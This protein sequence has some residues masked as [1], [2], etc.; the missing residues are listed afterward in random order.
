MILNPIT[1]V[2]VGTTKF[3]PR[4]TSSVFFWG[5][6]FPKCEKGNILSQYTPFSEKITTFQ[7]YYYYYL[8]FFGAT[9]GL[10]F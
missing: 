6:K 2:G 10:C 5:I 9:F 4:V 3:T 7:D 1:L 8:V